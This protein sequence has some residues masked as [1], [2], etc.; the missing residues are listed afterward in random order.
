MNTEAQESTSVKE[1]LH[2]A[3]EALP[4][5]LAAETLDFVEFI[6]ARR[7]QSKSETEEKL[8]Y[9][10]ASGRSVLR[11]V[12]KWAGDDLQECL[13]AARASRGLTEF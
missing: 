8:P 5:E 1:L 9:R 4:E 12:G 11:H 6:Q 13:E 10:P 3:I 2:Q 7:T